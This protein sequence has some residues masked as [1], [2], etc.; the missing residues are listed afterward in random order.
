M[1][2]DDYFSLDLLEQSPDA[3]LLFDSDGRILFANSETENLFGY[4]R[5]ELEQ[6]LL[7]ILVPT[8]FHNR[9]LSL[10]R[11]YFHAAQKR[12]MRT[13]HMDAF[14]RR[15]NQTEFPLQ[16]TLAPLKTEEGPIVLA[17]VRDLTERR[18]TE[19][20]LRESEQKYRELIEAAND[21]ILIIDMDS[22]TVSEANDQAGKLFGS[23]PAILTGR[24]LTD[25]FAAPET[26]RVK[27][28]FSELAKRGR[29][30]AKGFHAR[31]RAGH[32]IPVEISSSVLSLT[33]RQIMQI[34][35][36]DVS[37]E[38]RTEEIL[39]ERARQQAV[40]TKIGRLALVE[41]DIEKLM[42]AIVEHTAQTL[43]V[44]FSIILEF[45][46]EKDAFVPR[47]GVGWTVGSSELTLVPKDIRSQAGYTLLSN[48]PVV[49]TDFD[50]ESRFQSA[51]LAEHAVKSGI[52]VIIRAGD[53]PFGVLEA[54]TLRHRTF[55][56]D[57]VNFLRAIAHVLAGAIDRRRAEE[58]LRAKDLEIRQAY[59]EVIFAVTGGKLVI[60]SEE[61][62]PGNLG[63]T[64]GE[65]FDISTYEELGN[66][67]AKLREIIW[68]E[69]PSVDLDE[70]ITAAGEAAT[71]AVKHSGG[72]QITVFRTDKA[73]Q[74]MIKDS[75]PGIDFS[76]LPRATLM[77]G[78]ST[79]QTLGLG[80]TIMLEFC[81]RLLLSTSPEGTTLVLEIA[82]GTH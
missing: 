2:P 47:A 41:P 15:K 44:E 50:K 43:G 28:R 53:D 54:Q 67:R 33:D 56:D 9:H 17:T 38:K 10:C 35:F 74:I 4:T 59:V 81:D 78:F 8:R 3:V 58:S 26:A 57:D 20:A 69:F 21:A 55:T 29:G 65:A 6:E 68:A 16:V 64:I 18:S 27:R 70:T 42:D 73:V 25:L 34:I 60:L 32:S 46:R 30:T 49:V 11:E 72:G 24:Q 40:V 51:L 19:A 5:S 62:I 22:L 12:R 7:A 45:V 37:E 79:K 63:K 52:S 39:A 48:R 75:G 80:F 31:G 71:N 61:E 66:A 13:F 36:R 23:A 82:M 14:G 77:S 76:L 1:R